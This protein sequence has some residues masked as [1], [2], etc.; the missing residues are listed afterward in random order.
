M[1]SSGI[2]DPVQQANW[3][4]A[5]AFCNKLSIAEGFDKAY[6]VTGVNFSSLTFAEIPTTDNADWNTATCDWSSNGS[7]A[8]RLK[9]N[10]CGLQWGADQ[11]SEPGAMVGG[12]NITGYSKAFAGSNGS[13][14]IGDYAWYG[15]N[16]SGSA[17]ARTNSPDRQE[18]FP[19]WV[20]SD[21]ALDF[22]LWYSHN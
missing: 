19:W 15:Y 17:N 18:I 22:N 7:T 21:D 1:Y 13:N 14:A 5:I 6:S 20:D 9:W 4:H 10:G 11:D 2:T 8:C 16:Y 12:V 3:Y